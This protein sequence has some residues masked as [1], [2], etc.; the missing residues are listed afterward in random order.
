MDKFTNK[1]IILAI[2]S[3]LIFSPAA[4]ATPYFNGPYVGAGLGVV[5]STAKTNMDHDLTNGT[6][7]DA[8]KKDMDLG[9][10]GVNA[11][12]FLGLGHTFNNSYYLGG[13]LFANYFSPEMKAK[14]NIISPFFYSTKIKNPYSFGADI[15]LGYVIFQRVM[16]YGLIGAD[17]TKFE[18]KNEI[19]PGSYNI[20][21]SSDSFNKYIWGIVPGFGV[22]IGLS[23]HFSLRTQYTYTFYPSFSDTATLPPGTRTPIVKTKVKPNR[24]LFSAD[25]SYLFTPGDAVNNPHQNTKTPY[26]TGLYLGVG[27]GVAS[28]YN[29]LDSSYDVYD[30][31][32]AKIPMSLNG[33]FAK[34]GLNANVLLGYGKIL[35]DYYY[36][37]S[38][39][40]A[41]YFNAKTKYSYYREQNKES[42]NGQIKNPYS[43]GID[44]RGGYLILPRVMLYALLGTDYSKF[45]IKSNG[46][47][48]KKYNLWKGSV[49]D[50]FNK[51]RWGIMP[52]VGVEVS[53]CDHLSMR[54][55]Y[56]YTF[57][58]SFSHTATGIDENGNTQSLTTKVR[59]DRSAF[60]IDFSYLWNGL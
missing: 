51:Y 41:N 44:I 1:G 35:K 14:V 50:N 60:T 17:Y 3:A 49:Q 34:H 24:G 52:G 16:L 55:Q 26:F 30:S 31:S 5:T 22:E 28:L 12:L 37:G 13:E 38:E 10:H 6:V 20:P 48:K 9:Q 46:S 40:F 32:N 15:R 39:L 29:K 56:T 53:L 8:L 25:L 2:L 23:N 47:I 7:D 27:G 59:P 54:A 45:A 11:N 42:I 43:F 33:N 36:L 19:Y 18:I 57:Y 4:L 58:Q 21:Q